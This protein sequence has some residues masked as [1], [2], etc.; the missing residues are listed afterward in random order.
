MKYEGKRNAL[1]YA[2]LNNRMWIN[3]I[4]MLDG[5]GCTHCIYRRVMSVARNILC[6]PLTILASVFPQRTSAVRNMLPLPIVCACI[7]SADDTAI[8]TLS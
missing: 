3:F 5:F 8:S 6:L 2:A 7:N 4:F 1:Q